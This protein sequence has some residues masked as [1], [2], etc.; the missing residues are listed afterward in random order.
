METEKR[1][2]LITEYKVY[3]EKKYLNSNKEPFGITIK[4]KSKEYLT[5]HGTLKGILVKKRVFETKLG[6]MKIV[7]V[8]N[9]RGLFVVII[10]VKDQKNQKGHVELKLHAS[11][12]KGATTELKKMS[13]V[14]YFYVELLKSMITMFL[15]GF[16]EG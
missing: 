13:G 16:I 1:E 9:D 7:N 2:E 4:G 12:K 6:G 10:E 3:R 15:D 5:A 8:T 11:G 14:E